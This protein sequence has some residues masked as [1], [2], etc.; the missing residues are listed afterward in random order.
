M[1]TAFLFLFVIVLQVCSEEVNETIPTI[2][3]EA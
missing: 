3:K 1:K 2:S